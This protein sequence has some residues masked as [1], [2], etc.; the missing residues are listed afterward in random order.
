MKRE[1]LFLIAL[2][3]AAFAL[4]T[5]LADSAFT[6]ADWVSMGGVPGA[7]GIVYAMVKDK[8]TGIVYAGGAFTVIG[9]TIATNIAKRNGT[10]WSPVG[11][12][13]NGAVRALA[14]DPSGNL[15]AGGLFTDP[16]LGATNIAKWNG[17][18]WS[19]MGTGLSGQVLAVA[20]D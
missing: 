20:A 15:Y 12:G 13:I 17:S 11:N 3:A 10:S 8:N 18:A 19:G 4:T 1:A 2:L 7:N 6:D 5:G 9:S 16:L 14:V